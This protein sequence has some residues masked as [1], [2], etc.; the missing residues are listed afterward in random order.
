MWILT[1]ELGV[2]TVVLKQRLALRE[3]DYKSW[4]FNKRIGGNCK[5]ITCK[6]NYKNFLLGGKK[7]Q[8]NNFLYKEE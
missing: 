6:K 7:A 2:K 1:E 8:D 5:E 4:V 3:V